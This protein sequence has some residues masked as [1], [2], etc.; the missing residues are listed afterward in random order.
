MSASVANGELKSKMAA[1]DTAGG[2]AAEANDNTG[3]V[4]NSPTL[5]PNGRKNTTGINSAKREQSLQILRDCIDMVKADGVATQFQEFTSKSGKP[6]ILIVLEDCR[7][8]NDD[9]IT[10]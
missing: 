1:N 8:A 6:C 7:V 9:F 4:A 2:G 3:V 5:T 10:G